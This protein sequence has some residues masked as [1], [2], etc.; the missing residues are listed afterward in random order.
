MKH[1]FNRATVGADRQFVLLWSGVFVVSLAV[2]LALVVALV[3]KGQLLTIDQ[4][5]SSFVQSLRTAWG[6]RLMVGVTMLGDG[7]VLAP[8][9][10]GTV[11]WLGWRKIWCVAG[12]VVAAF[13]FSSAF[14]PCIKN[15]VQRA[16][17]SDFY[18]GSEAFSFP[19]GHATLSA[20]I[21]GVLAILISVQES[22]RISVL[23]IPIA[24]ALIVAIA[25]SRIYLGAHWP[26]DVVAGASFGLAVTATVA[27]A[28]KR[29]AIPRT[30]RPSFALFAI[31]LFTILASVHMIINFHTELNKYKASHA[32]AP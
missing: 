6:D 19:S 21:L 11:F 7:K 4:S 10:V 17:P 20:S 1:K 8:L 14:V 23:A 13:V 26:S 27:L 5:M 24:F 22:R 9:A 29:V 2:F 3:E 12:I 18:T 30:S 25:F 32:L 15:I 16:R 28:L 31:G